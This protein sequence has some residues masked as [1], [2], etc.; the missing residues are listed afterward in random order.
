MK[1]LWTAHKIGYIYFE[2]VNCKI[3]IQKLIFL[4]SFHNNLLKYVVTNK[5]G[6]QSQ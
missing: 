1:L 4:R 6:P 5:K 3:H 2:Q